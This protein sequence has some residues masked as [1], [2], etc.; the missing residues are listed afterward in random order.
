MHPPA[1]STPVSAVVTLVSAF[2]VGY[3]VHSVF[4]AFGVSYAEA[5]SALEDFKQLRAAAGI[6]V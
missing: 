6:K 3:S 1:Y 5:A 4:G 2:V